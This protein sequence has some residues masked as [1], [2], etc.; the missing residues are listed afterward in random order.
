MDIWYICFM[1]RDFG[2]GAQINSFYYTDFLTEKQLKITRN[3]K[4]FA[5]KLSKIEKCAVLLCSMVLVLSLGYALGREDSEILFSVSP[6]S[7]T[8]E[9]PTPQ[10]VSTEKL[11]INTASAE[12]LEELIGIGPVLARRIIEYRETRGGF[13]II[14]DI[15]KVQGIGAMVFENVR[16][17]ICVE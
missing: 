1:Q 5:I 7:F 15:T 17:Y 9:R 2:A 8:A 4:S 12:E 3:M 13:K 11:N 10:G 16:D 14:E 6:S